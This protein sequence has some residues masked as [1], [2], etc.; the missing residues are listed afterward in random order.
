[1]PIGD[2]EPLVNCNPIIKGGDL[3]GVL[4]NSDPFL[5]SEQ[6]CQKI[7]EAYEHRLYSSITPVGYSKGALLVRR[8]PVYGYGQIEDLE[9]V[10]GEMRDPMPWVRSVERLVLLASMNRGWTL[11]HR[12][13][14]MPRIRFWQ[15][16]L[17]NQVTRLTGTC[18]D[19]AKAGGR[20]SPI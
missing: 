11:R 9:F 3:L 18:R 10:A 4:S 8:A 15:Y 1:M 17:A 14:Q 5:I 20:S 7:L 12:P 19:D 6:I 13:K 2:L 16:K